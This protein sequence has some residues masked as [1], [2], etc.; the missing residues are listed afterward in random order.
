MRRFIFGERDGIYI[1]DLQQTM[2]LLD[3]AP[4]TS[5]NIGE[6]NGS[7]LFVGT[8]KQARTP[9]QSTPGASACPTSTTAGW[10]AC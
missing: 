9:S 5:A 3:E 6:R 10:V 8:K 2:A 7:V 4:A 1:I